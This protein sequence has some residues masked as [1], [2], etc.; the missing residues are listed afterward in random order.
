VIFIYNLL[1]PL[2]FIFFIPGMIIKLLKRSGHKNSYLERFALYSREKRQQLK[3]Y[4]GATWIHS[5]S[6]GETVIALNLIEEWRKT[7]PDRKF[8]LS[9]TTTTG[10]ELAQKRV[11]ENV[12]VI[13]CPIDFYLF[14]RRAVKMIRPP[15]LVILETE[16]WPN[17]LKQVKKNGGHTVLVNGRMSDKSSRGYYRF[18]IFFRSVFSLF[19]EVCVQTTIDMERYKAVA[20]QLNCQVKGNMKF[21]QRLPEKLPN[22]DLSEYFGTAPVR[23]I[24]AASTHPGEEELIASLFKKLRTEFD[25]LKLIIIP[26]HAERGNEIAKQLEQLSIS[27]IQRS[28][29]SSDSKSVNCLLADTTG[30]MLAFIQQA[31]LVIMGKSLAGHDEGH[32]I[33]EPAMLGKAIVTGGTLKNFRFVLNA[34]T[35]RDAIVTVNHDSELENILIRMFKNPELLKKYGEAAKQVTEEHC[36]ATQKIIKTLENYN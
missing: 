31:D 26:R 15:L 24:L 19:D 16:I 28:K 3:A 8:V 1:F 21:D 20:P 9:T 35:Q 4:Q 34:F 36:G 18:R 29:N 7:A 12:A 30:E 14:V 32:N 2:G 17:L 23:V 25:D 33:I 13:F 22:I 5:V 10:Q 11:S 6:V 27:F